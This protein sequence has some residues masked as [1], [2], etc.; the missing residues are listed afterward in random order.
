MFEDRLQEPVTL[1]VP[2]GTFS[3]GQS[4]YAEYSAYALITDFTQRDINRYGTV[5]N[6]KI[7]LLRCGHEPLP[8][9]R[10]SSREKTYDIKDIKV[11]RNLDGETECYRCVVA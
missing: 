2:D 8:G 4:G 10:I 11:C 1:Q 6:G 5:K 9:S 3:D 7:F